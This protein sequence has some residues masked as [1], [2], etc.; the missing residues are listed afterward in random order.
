MASA[1]AVV[2][3]AVLD[4]A[5]VAADAACR[6][7]LPWL[8]LVL[9]LLPRLLLLLWQMRHVAVAAAVANAVALAV[10]AVVADACCCGCRCCRN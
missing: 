2:G 5:A 7:L 1:A 9:F 4:V 3:A 10:A 6:V 8:L